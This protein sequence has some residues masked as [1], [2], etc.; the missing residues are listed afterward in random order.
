MK[1]IILFSIVLVFVSSLSFADAFAPSVMKFVAEDEIIYPFD[2]TNVS[3]DF[4][5]ENKPAQ[6][7]LVVTTKDK[8][9]DIVGVQN[10]FLGWHYVNKIDTTVYVSGKYT[11][12]LGQ[13]TIVWDGKNQDGENVVPDEYYYYLWGVDNI[14]ARTWACSFMGPSCGWGSRTASFVD[15]DVNDLPLAQPYIFANWIW[16]TYTYANNNPYASYCR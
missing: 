4:T 14:S 8:S 16:W 15:H 1:K 9:A 3:I 12:A 5:L 2:G 7:F 13:N 10:G 11:K 6:V